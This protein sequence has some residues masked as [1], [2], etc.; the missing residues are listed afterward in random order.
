MST[1]SRTRRRVGVAGVCLVAAL[2]VGVGTWAMVDLP[3]RS[4]AA[5]DEQGARARSTAPV[6]RGDLT[7]SR[8]FAGTLGYGAPVALQANATGTITALPTPGQVIHRDEPLYAVDERPVRSMHGTVPL[9]RD[10]E[11]GRRG[12]DVQQLNQN[13]AALGYDVAQDDTFG[14]RTLAAV[15]RWQV[16][17]HLARSGRLTANDVAFV[18]GDVR[19]ASVAAELGRAAGGA[20]FSVTNT[21][22]VVN[23]TVPAQDAERL[24]V[25]TEVQVRINGAGDPLPGKVVDA[26]PDDS[27][28]G[29]SK[30]VVTVAIDAG[31][32]ELPAAASAQLTAPGRTERDVLTV[33]VAALLAGKGEGTY[34][35]EVPASGG[36]T[37]RVTVQ[38]GFVADGRAVVTGRVSEGDRVVVPS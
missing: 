29:S 21:R 20:V 1:S 12:A 10:L 13:L 28:E 34:A 3:Q 17:R 36:G 38:V 14:R 37:R 11:F 22:R 15:Q 35:V 32:R 33:P 19:V 30:V 5:A 7:E 16:D 27:E 31:D 2:G 9:W 4:A 18:D 6:T 23:A 24:A 8:V 26:A 25:G